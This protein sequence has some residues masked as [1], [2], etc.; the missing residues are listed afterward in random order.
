MTEGTARQ[1][2]S[3]LPVERWQLNRFFQ[4]AL[5]TTR[6]I[7]QNHRLSIIMWWW[8]WV[9]IV[10]R[11][12]HWNQLDSFWD[13]RRAYYLC[14][15]PRSV[16][17][18]YTLWVMPVA[19]YCRLPWRPDRSISCEVKYYYYWSFKVQWGPSLIIWCTKMGSLGHLWRH[20]SSGGRMHRQSG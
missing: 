2:R 3:T 13:S 5:L 12:G 20:L 4:Q 15:I 18:V 10:V 7:L 11:S 16:P 8:T 14:H 1:G 17:P 19:S 6:C 9:V